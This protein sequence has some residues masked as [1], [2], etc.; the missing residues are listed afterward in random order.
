MARAHIEC[1]RCKR[2][3]LGYA[4]GLCRSCYTLSLYYRHRGRPLPP[5]RVRVHRCRG[6]GNAMPGRVGLCCDDGC[7]D[8]TARRR[9]IRH[10]AQRLAPWR[11]FFGHLQ[12][13]EHVV[14]EQR[15]A[16][17]THRAIGE[18]HG[19]TRQYSQQVEQSA[20]R[21]LRRA[22]RTYR[23]LSSD[24]PNGRCPAHGI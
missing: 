12:V 6:C 15:L 16:G 8:R 23:R 14:L 4:R 7:R 2:E 5:Y 18:A 11:S 24:H 1:H 3:R 22:A 10:A 21:T 19:W 17:D 13:R 9:R 20:I